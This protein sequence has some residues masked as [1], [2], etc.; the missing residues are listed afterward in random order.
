MSWLWRICPCGPLAFTPEP[1]AGSSRLVSTS[2]SR[3]APRGSRSARRRAST[4]A[5]GTS[6]AAACSVLELG[7]ERVVQQ[8]P[9]AAALALRCTA[10]VAPFCFRYSCAIWPSRRGGRSPRSRTALPQGVRLG[11]LRRAACRC[12]RSASASATKSSVARS[13]DDLAPRPGAASAARGPC[14]ARATSVPP[15][16]R[17]RAPAARTASRSSPRRSGR[18]TAW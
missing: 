6:A 10:S 18:T 11:R 1:S 3:L 4:G 13:R 17:G 12:A 8:R 9:G 15:P 14:R 5:P 2:S 7:V 16:A